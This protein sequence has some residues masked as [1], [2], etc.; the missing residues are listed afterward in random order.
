MPNRSLYHNS[1]QEERSSKQNNEFKNENLSYLDTTLSKIL[2]DRTPSNLFNERPQSFGEV[3]SVPV[4]IR[5]KFEDIN[6]TRT[7]D[8]YKSSYDK[9]IYNG[10]E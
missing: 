1:I 2:N 3:D 9:Q 4:N 7:F 6:S 8:S 5:K 10:R